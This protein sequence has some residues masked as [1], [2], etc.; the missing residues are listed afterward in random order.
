MNEEANQQSNATAPPDPQP[1]GALPELAL[2]FLKLGTIAFGGPAAHIALMEDEVV[3]RR[4]WVSQEE[5]LDLVGATNLIP[6]PN[7]TELA[8]HIGYRRAGWPG[9]FVAGSC[10]IFPAMLIVMAF[11]WAYVRY[12][13]LPSV[14]GLLYGVKPVIIAIVAQAL[15]RLSRVAVK[16]NLLAVFTVL[17]V[18]AC[19][20]GVNELVVLFLSGFL[21]AL[22]RASNRPASGRL[23]GFVP[24]LGIAGGTVA[25][26]GTAAAA[27][28]SL[29]LMFFF[30]FK[31]GAVLFGSGYVLL[32]FLR[33]DLVERWGWLTEN[34]LLDA[35]AVGQ[36]T[37]GPVFTTATFIG[38]L[39]GGPGPALLATLGIFL[40]AFLFVA[41]SSPF[42]P[43]LRQ[44]P[45]AGG[46]LDGVNA[47]SLALMFVVTWQLGAAALVDW[48]TTA[49]AVM[50][51]VLL[52]R[53]RVNS[54]WLVLGGATVGLVR[55]LV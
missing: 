17:A 44:S 55:A 34:Q 39:L 23:N 35:V 18:T 8:I 25:A 24:V 54:F 42:I 49:L 27:P 2:L 32:A 33:A 11:A 38:Y 1:R 15:W 53:Y 21:I 16:T 29:G 9:L 6:G 51:V 28:F 50:A 22:V 26:T 13:S 14:E 43:K 37:P 7:S 41:I 3:R 40:P 5:F 10:F 12:G 31:V 20:L 4:R 45:V 52:L 47:A 46:F 19:F 36:V 30:F 48:L